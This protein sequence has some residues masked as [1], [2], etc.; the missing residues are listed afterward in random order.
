[1]IGCGQIADAHLQQ[2]QRIQG[3]NAVAV[4]DLNRH[5]AEQAARRFQ[6][7][8]WFTDVE[9][10]IKEKNLDVVHITTP[11]ASHAFLAKVAIKYGLHIYMEKPFTT[12][13]AEAEEIVDLAR[14]MGCQ[15]CAGHSSAFDPS[16]LGL[17]QAFEDGQLGEL[18]HLNAG[19]GYGLGGPFGKVM[20]SEAGHWVH[21]LPGGIPHN[22]I[23]HPVSLILG[24]W[25]PTEDLKV[26]ARGFKWREERFGDRRD[27]FFDELRISIMGDHCSAN[28]VFSA[29][30]RPLELY[31]DTFGTEAIARLNLYSRTLAF[32]RGA[33]L[34]G[35][36]EKVNWSRNYYK[37]AQRGYRKN[38]KNLFKSNIHYFDGMKNLMEGLYHSIETG[39]E[40]PIPMEEALR[41]TRIID[42]IFESVRE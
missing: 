6:I 23:S 7:D 38:L 29:K 2:I 26:T 15:I 30:I 8:G 27:D 20:M 33:S 21:D 24:L 37:E 13:L 5:M 40:I 25:K 18:V 16:F 14:E 41:A 1:M 9:E 4:C 34:P 11:P 10:M 19:M 35:P 36:F 42:E 17:V 28:I 3:A 22:N 12:N 39:A 32:D 31:L